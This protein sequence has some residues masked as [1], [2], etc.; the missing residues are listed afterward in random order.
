M[1]RLIFFLLLVLPFVGIGQNK[2]P[3]FL[4]LSNKGGIMMAHRPFMTHLVRDKTYGFEL[5][6]SKQQIGNSSLSINHKYP[7][8]GLA[9][10]FRNF[11]YDEVL[12]KAISVLQYQNFVLF[13]TKKNLCL[14]FKFGYGVAYIT[15][16][17]DK[18]T[19]PTNNAI[20]S[21]VNSK[22]VFKIELNKFTTN[23]HFGLGLE[24]SHYSNGAIQHPNLGLNSFAIYANMGYNFSKRKV[25]DSQEAKRNKTKL[26]SKGYFI[27]E[28]IISMSETEPIPKDAKKY[29]VFAGRFSF[30][31][32]LNSSW[33]FELGLDGVYNVS[34]Q[35]KYPE[36]NH[37]AKDVTQLGLYAGLSF[38]YYNSQIIMGMGY[39]FVDIINPLGRIYNRVGYRYYFN[40]QVFGLFNIRANFGKADFFELGIGYKFSRK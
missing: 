33:N 18:I 15:K 3:Y 23:Y 9:L 26:S 25:F 39:Y 20:G 19:N 1:K 2:T 28:G 12:G 14:D 40:E 29:P 36:K 16:K 38:N 17:Y 13:Q 10:E 8:N 5:S 37:E 21:H 35:Y 31:K 34:N 4:T 6:L 24:L 11:G 22:A 32:P 27:G 30:A 7:L